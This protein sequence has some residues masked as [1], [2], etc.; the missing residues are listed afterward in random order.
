[1][2]RRCVEPVV[3]ASLTEILAHPKPG[4]VT[5]YSPWRRLGY[6]TAAHATLQPYVYEAALRGYMG[7]GGTYT[8]GDLLLRSV[9]DAVALGGREELLGE[10]L[11][12]LPLAYGCGRGERRGRGVAGRVEEAVAVLR[13]ESTV[14]DAVALYRAIRIA[15]PS[16]VKRGHHG[17]YPDIWSPG[18]AEE[19]RR[20]GVTLW[21]IIVD[22]AEREL[23]FNE[24]RCGYCRSLDAARWASRISLGYEARAVCIYMYLLARY[25]DTVVERRHG[26]GA[27]ETMLRLAREVY[28]ASGIRCSEDT[29]A[30]AEGLDHVFRSRGWSPGSVADL[31]AAALAVLFMGDAIGDR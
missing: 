1:M 21:D 16:H 7:G 10:K 18:Y 8:V 22:A 24:L 29:A 5:R 6:F 31:A 19:L 11:L 27:A 30:A 4:A 14:E 12:L 23:V 9:E 17:R 25:R 3:M 26:A 20:R 2:I 13:T 15:G 28:V